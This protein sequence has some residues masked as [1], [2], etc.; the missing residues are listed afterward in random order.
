MT[1]D[2]V[3]LPDSAAV[4]VLLDDDD[5]EVGAEHLLRERLGAALDTRPSCLVVDLVR[6]R[7]VD[8]PGARVLAE[9]AARGAEQDCTVSVLNATPE[10]RRMLDLA[11]EGVLQP[12]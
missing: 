4:T 7:W 8:A 3:S 1:V 2:V 9:A 10:A 5:L 6:C 12:G 11:A